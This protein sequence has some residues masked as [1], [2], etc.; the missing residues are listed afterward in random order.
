MLQR[1]QV[2]SNHLKLIDSTITKL[3]KNYTNH[4]KSNLMIK[5]HNPGTE[6][7]CKKELKSNLEELNQTEKY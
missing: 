4:K 3:C 5:Q 2:Y 7:L 1:T 6:A